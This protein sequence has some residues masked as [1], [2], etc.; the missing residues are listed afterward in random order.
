MARPRVR[1]ID[2]SVPMLFPV[3]VTLL[4]SG[5]AALAAAIIK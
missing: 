2:N 5:G 3:V 1:I 4:L